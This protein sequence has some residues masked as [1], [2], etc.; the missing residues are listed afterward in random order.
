MS[1]RRETTD[2]RRVRRG[3]RRIADLE[4]HDESFITIDQFAAFLK[5]DY[6]T[7]KYQWI[8]K[9]ALP[10]YSFEGIW[11]IKLT[12]AVAFVQRNRLNA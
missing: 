10:A 6:R 2:R 1:D 4:S 3:G 11:R 7:V 9:G 5:V 8:A 12:D